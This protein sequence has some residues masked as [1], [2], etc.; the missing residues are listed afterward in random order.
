MYSLFLSLSVTHRRYLPLLT[1]IDFHAS[2]DEFSPSYLHYHLFIEIH[3]GN[4]VKAVTSPLT[5]ML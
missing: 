2:A 3:A 5:Y 4:A 1:F